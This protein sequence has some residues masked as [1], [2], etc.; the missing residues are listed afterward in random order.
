[1]LT[2]GQTK[3]EHNLL[4]QTIQTTEQMEAMHSEM[5]MGSIKQKDFEK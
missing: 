2:S 3:T 5:M 1:M 4:N